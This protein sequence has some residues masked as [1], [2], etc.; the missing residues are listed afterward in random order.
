LSCLV[1]K[2][3]S[4]NFLVSDMN[5]YLEDVLTLPDDLDEEGD[6]YSEL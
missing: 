1:D 4:A 6:D 2:L 3:G 5:D